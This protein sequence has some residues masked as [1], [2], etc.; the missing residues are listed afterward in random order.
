MRRSRLDLV[1]RYGWVVYALSLPPAG[2]SL[3]LHNA[4]REPSL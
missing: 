1:M 2:V 4:G 3:V